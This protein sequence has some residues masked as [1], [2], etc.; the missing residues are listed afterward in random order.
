MESNISHAIQEIVA[1]LKN[2]NIKMNEIEFLFQ[3]SKKLANKIT[4]VGGG[5]I[6]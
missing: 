5:K 3:E 1:V 2:N 6:G 4:I